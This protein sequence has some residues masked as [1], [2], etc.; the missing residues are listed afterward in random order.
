MKTKKKKEN[1]FILLTPEQKALLLL[2]NKILDDLQKTELLEI[3]SRQN[4]DWHQFFE[5]SFQHSLW[6]I[7]YNKLKNNFPFLLPQDIDLKFHLLNKHTAKRNIFLLDEFQKILSMFHDHGIQV[8][9][10]KGL[11]LSQRLYEDFFSKT[12]TDIDLLVPI[13]AIQK[14]IFLL[15]S[16]LGYHSYNHSPYKLSSLFFWEKDLTLLK[17][18]LKRIR[19]HQFVSSIG[20]PVLI[21]YWTKNFWNQHG[22]NLPCLLL[23][24]FPF[25]GCL[26]KMNFFFY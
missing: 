14:A 1:N 6:P 19:P 12:I 2:S 9:P 21:G 5:L 11:E 16:K 4:F 13:P 20:L 25:K 18:N 7:V 8:I 17:K 10:L 24:I 26:K 3:F 15:H 23:R 22:K